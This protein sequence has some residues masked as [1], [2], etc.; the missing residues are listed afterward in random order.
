MLF[1]FILCLVATCS[2]LC[3]AYAYSSASRK[4]DL[5]NERMARIV[6]ED[7]VLRVLESEHSE[8]HSTARRKAREAH[9]SLESLVA[10]AGGYENLTQA[11]GIDTESLATR[12][13]SHYK[14]LTFP[15]S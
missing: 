5:K 13:A 11:I 9:A 8:D 1:T 15:S 6:D 2:V 7:V 3:L 12:I 14:Y 4:V 10:I